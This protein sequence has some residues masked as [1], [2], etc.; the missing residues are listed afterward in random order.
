MKNNKKKLTLTTIVFSVIAIT[1]FVNMK[2]HDAAQKGNILEA[3]GLL[4]QNHGENINETDR[5]GDTALHLAIANNKLSMV[6]YLLENHA[7]VAKVNNEGITPLYE[8][9]AAGNNDAIKLLLDRGNAQETIDLRSGKKDGGFYTPLHVAIMRS[10][11]ATVQLLLSRGANPAIKTIDGKT[12]YELA[13]D[14]LK[15]SKGSSY[16]DKQQKIVEI[17]RNYKGNK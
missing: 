14:W 5:H 2:L 8:A 7:Q 15:E 6:K 10:H 13:E 3:E 11:P 16:H 1:I 9:A 17:L 12:A 4:K